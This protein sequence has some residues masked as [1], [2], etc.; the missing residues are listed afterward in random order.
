MFFNLGEQIA[1]VTVSILQDAFS[2]RTFDKNAFTTAKVPANEEAAFSWMSNKEIE[3]S[4]IITEQEPFEVQH[5]PQIAIMIGPG[6]MKNVSFDQYLEKL[7]ENGKV[8]GDIIG[9]GGE[10]DITVRCASESTGQRKKLSDR[11]AAHLLMDREKF[12]KKFGI[13][14]QNVRLAGYGEIPYLQGDKRI[15][16]QDL[17]IHCWGEWSAEIRKDL[18][19]LGGFR[20]HV[21][22]SRQKVKSSVKCLWNIL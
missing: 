12:F 10:F 18:L 13:T 3:G 14:M 20:F 8:V 17:T 4:L 1:F 19:K 7:K 11:V 21:I 22:F 9:G 15:Y 16:Y 6:D 5:F 2:D